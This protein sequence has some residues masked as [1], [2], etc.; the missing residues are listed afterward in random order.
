MKNVAASVRQR[1]MNLAKERHVAFNRI[2]VQYG[3]ERVLYRLSLHDEFSRLQTPN[4]RWPSS[5]NRSTLARWN[6]RGKC[7]WSQYPARTSSMHG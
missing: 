7:R 6:V 1:L 4:P 3:I 5:S 2:L